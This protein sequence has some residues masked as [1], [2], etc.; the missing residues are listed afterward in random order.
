MKVL[1]KEPVAISNA[2]F[3]DLRDLCRTGFIPAEHR[4][5]NSIDLLHSHCIKG[6][7]E[8]TNVEEDDVELAG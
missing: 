1:Y 2:K 3:K 7:L 5:F 6:R 4:D 8:E